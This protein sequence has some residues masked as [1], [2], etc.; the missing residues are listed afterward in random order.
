MKREKYVIFTKLAFILFRMGSVR[1]P[2]P[3]GFCTERLRYKSP[4]GLI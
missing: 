2:T 3:L 4:M 1:L